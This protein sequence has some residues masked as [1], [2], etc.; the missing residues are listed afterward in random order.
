MLIDPVLELSSNSMQNYVMNYN[1]V[2]MPGS[3]SLVRGYWSI[4]TQAAY[5]GHRDIRKVV[6]QGLI[7]LKQCIK[8]VSMPETHLNIMKNKENE[9]VS[10]ALQILRGELFAESSLISILENI[11]T[12]FFVLREEDVNEWDA[13]SKP[14]RQL[15]NTI[16]NLSRIQRTG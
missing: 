1:Y 4:V 15:P 8:L 16:T 3:M 9:Q 10:Q 14:T 7:L 2:L 11:I 13:V 12:L 5:S 6:L